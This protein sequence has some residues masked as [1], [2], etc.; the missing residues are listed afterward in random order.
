ME[1]EFELSHILTYL[2]PTSFSNLV[3]F[4]KQ[5]YL[6]IIFDNTFHLNVDI[7]SVISNFILS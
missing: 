4:P 6:N 1:L 2:Y 3:N 7:P 5:T